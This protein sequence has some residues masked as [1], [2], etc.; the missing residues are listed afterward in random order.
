ALKIASRGPLAGQAS[1]EL[2]RA[3]LEM[4][5]S[6]GEAAEA[7]SFGLIFATEDMR[8]GTKSFLEKRKPDFQGR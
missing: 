7:D 4:G 8:E 2:I 3:G 5:Q 6:Q 1:L